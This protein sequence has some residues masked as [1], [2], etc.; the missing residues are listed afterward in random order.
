MPK[1]KH[2]ENDGSSSV[3]IIATQGVPLDVHQ[4]H[5]LSTN[6]EDPK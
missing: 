5:I 3:G 6:D 2:P 4:I 1:T